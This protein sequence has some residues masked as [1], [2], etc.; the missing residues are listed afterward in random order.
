MYNSVYNRIIINWTCLFILQ[1]FYMRIF[2]YFSKKPSS[3]PEWQLEAATTS[4]SYYIILYYIL[5]ILLYSLFTNL[6]PNVSWII[7]WTL[8]LYWVWQRHNWARSKPRELNDQPAIGPMLISIRG[9]CTSCWP[10]FGYLVLSHTIY[11]SS[12]S[13]W[14]TSAQQNARCLGP[15]C[16]WPNTT[17]LAWKLA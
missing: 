13:A 17:L 10:K 5:Y 7:T 9:S 6:C 3:D 11:H 15:T 12:S 16:M 8:V 1:M 4:L 2:L 14:I